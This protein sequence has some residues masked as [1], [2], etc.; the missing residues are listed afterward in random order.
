MSRGKGKKTQQAEKLLLVL[1]NA[2]GKEVTID[3][4]KTTLGAEVQLYR[5][6]TY[7]WDLKKIGADISK[8]KAGRSLVG[9]TLNNTDHM[10][11]YAKDRGLIAPPPVTLNPEDL[12]VTK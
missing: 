5:L 12:M 6:P 7:L 8:R 4:V 10:V 11:V 9:F 1:L 3:E 2:Q